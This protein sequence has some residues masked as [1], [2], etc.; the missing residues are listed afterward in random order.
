M[1]DFDRTTQ[2]HISGTPAGFGSIDFWEWYAS[3]TLDGS[4][5]GGMAEFIIMKALGIKHERNI[6]DSYDLEYKGKRIE[7]K[8][9]SRFT[10]KN[11]HG[12]HHEYTENRRITYSIEPKH[13]HVIGG[14]WTS[15]KR[16]SDIYIF[17]LI[18]DMDI[19]NLA[20]WE[21]YIIP[22]ET[23]NK[24]FGNQKTLSLSAI[25]RFTPPPKKYSEIRAYIDLIIKGGIDMSY[26]PNT[27]KAAPADRE[28]EKIEL[29]RLIACYQVASP[30]DK[31]VVWAALNKYASQIDR[32]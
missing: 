14:D 12:F 9:A 26:D 30:D 3:Y 6:W 10:C 5:R 16:N 15:R 18:S 8:S 22:T 27:E 24:A 31:N 20:K 25:R 17:T 13:N 11:R 29:Q 21:F 1:Y 19:S 4:I 2:F 32:I 7:I 23:I 28:A